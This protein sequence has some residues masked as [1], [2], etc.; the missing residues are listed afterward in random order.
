MRTARSVRLPT[1]DE[2]AAAFFLANR[3]GLFV[4]DYGSQ[5]ESLG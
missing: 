5:L 1:P 2:L 3:D 4:R